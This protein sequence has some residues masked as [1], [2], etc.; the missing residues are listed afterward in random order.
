M[1]HSVK[2]G[3]WKSSTLVHDSMYLGH[4]QRPR[5]FWTFALGSTA[6]AR[7]GFKLTCPYENLLRMWHQ[8]SLN[9]W[10]WWGSG[11][12]IFS[13][14]LVFVGELVIPSKK[15]VHHSCLSNILTFWGLKCHICNQF[16]PKS[17]FCC[18]Q[19]TTKIILCP[20]ISTAW[21]KWYKTLM[22]IL[23][24]ANRTSIFFL[25]V[26]LRMW[27]FLYLWSS[28]QHWSFIYND[29]LS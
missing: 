10:W 27:H 3:T 20:F 21:S 22:N 9:S 18:D 8:C 23:L 29:S 6:A 28:A 4:I 12:N 15:M 7:G 26:A 11:W 16:T 24:Q 19:M 25:L 5:S 2:C 14:I 1:G 13:G 17:L